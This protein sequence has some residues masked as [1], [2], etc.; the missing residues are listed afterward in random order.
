MYEL[1]LMTAAHLAARDV[2]GVEITIVTHEQ[3]PL[4]LFG[5]A[6][7]KEV[8]ALLE[9]AGVRLLTMSFPAHVEDGHL[10][11]QNKD[12]LRADRV[13]A[14]PNLE[15]PRLPGLPQGSL[16]FIP[17]DLFGRVVGLENVYAAGDANWYPI[18]FGGTAA[19][20]ADAAAT[21]IAAAAGAPVEPIPFRPVLRGILLG[22]AQPLHLRYEAATGGSEAA[23]H[24]LWWP[25]GKV[26]GRY[27]APFLA[28]QAGDDQP[29]PPLSD[30]EP[31]D[32]EYPSTSEEDFEEGG[33]LALAAA[34]ASADWGDFESALRWLEAAEQLNVVLRPEF[35]EKRR[36]WRAALQAEP[37]D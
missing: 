18:K 30:I 21:A 15:V 12:V 37:K 11:L 6:V 2:E 36:A 25:P 10:V 23:L 17:T 4:D 14:L 13:V 29:A 9:Q 32:S 31:S 35:A 1:P 22:G 24:P 19:E 8:R 28:Q 33:E 16:G 5:P 7:G 27:L 20:Q 34:Q 3:E 26:A